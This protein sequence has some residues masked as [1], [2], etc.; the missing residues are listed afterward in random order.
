MAEVVG[1]VGLGAMGLGMAASVQRLLRSDKAPDTL[2]SKDLHVYNRTAS[3]A[4]PLTSNPDLRSQLAPSLS[5][6]GSK[7][8][9]ICLMLA[10]DVACGSV[11]QQLCSCGLKNKIIVNHSTNTPDFAR[12]ATTQVTAAGGVYISAPVWGRPD[13]AAAAK[14]IVVPAGPADAA[15]R[16]LPF[17]AAH[18]RLLPTQD[19][20]F[21]AN[22]MKLTGNFMLFGFVNT[23]CEAL[24]LS[25]KNDI[26]RDDILAFIE[27]FFPAPSIQGYAKRMA[28]ESLDAGAGFTGKYSAVGV[29]GSTDCCLLDGCL[30]EPWSTQWDSGVA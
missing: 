5:D 4:E 12:S 23:M 13:A 30:S 9:I 2:G 24:T 7:C 28:T 26:P 22:V 14:L 16:V 15:R 3:K 11:L 19:V 17:L 20:P 6:L 10:D 25:D 21:K 29:A 18:G 8:S 1:F 27:A